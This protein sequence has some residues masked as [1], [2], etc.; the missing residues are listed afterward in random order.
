[1]FE[2]ERERKNILM[3]KISAHFDRSCI[4]SMQSQHTQIHKKQKQIQLLGHSQFRLP[5]NP[6]NP[7][8]K[9]LLCIHK[10]I[11][12]FV[13]KKKKKTKGPKH[14]FNWHQKL[15]SSMCHTVTFFSFLR[16]HCHILN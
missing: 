10:T 1:M 13:S 3:K 5:K 15:V 9:S 8:F 4:T 16:E 14:S 2:R 6:A 12:L 11:N 7:L